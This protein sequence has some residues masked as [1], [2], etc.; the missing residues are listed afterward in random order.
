[1]NKID[2]PGNPVNGEVRN[3]DSPE[4]T[5]PNR[6]PIE[7]VTIS[8][9]RQRRTQSREKPGK[10]TKP[11]GEATLSDG[12]AQLPKNLLKYWKHVGMSKTELVVIIFMLVFWWDRD[13][14]IDPKLA[15]VAKL[16]GMDI[17]TI[18]TAL[19]N[20]HN[21]GIITITRQR[22]ADDNNS[23]T[24][25]AY[26]LRPLADLIE[27][28]AIYQASGGGALADDHEGADDAEDAD[29]ENDAH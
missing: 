12:F 3:D 10:R 15:T 24:S 7:T 14:P 22:D 17:K 29:N 6:R 23:L 9:K 21:K 16:S 4:P 18:R 13:N 2:D 11:W 19:N 26:D 20:L 8:R 27:E 28:E 1:M 25:N 5:K